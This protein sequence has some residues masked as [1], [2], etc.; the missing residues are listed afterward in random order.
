MSAH[1]GTS[2]RKIPRF[3][4]ILFFLLRNDFLP[5]DDLRFFLLDLL[6][7]RCLALLFRFFAASSAT[8]RRP[9]LGVRLG[10]LRREIR[11]SSVTEAS[12]GRFRLRRDR[13]AAPDDGVG[14]VAAGLRS[15][16]TRRMLGR[17]RGFITDRNRLSSRCPPLT[18]GMGG[19]RHRH[20]RLAS[21]RKVARQ[22]ERL[23]RLPIP[24]AAARRSAETRGTAD[25]GGGVASDSGGQT[26]SSASRSAAS[27][28]YLPVRS[29][30]GFL[31]VIPNGLARIT[32]SSKSGALR[33]H[34]PLLDRQGD[35]LLHQNSDPRANGRH[36]ADTWDRQRWRKLVV[37]RFVWCLCVAVDVRPAQHVSR[38]DRLVFRAFD[39]HPR[40]QDPAR[41]HLCF[42]DGVHLLARCVARK[43]VV[44]GLPIAARGRHRVLATVRPRTH[45]QGDG[46][47]HRSTPACCWGLLSPGNAGRQDQPRS[48]GRGLDRAASVTR[49]SR[50]IF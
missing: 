24:Q 20:P 43:S 10:M 38:R 27:D 42:P 8:A 36:M 33:S 39:V 6:A 30:S 34:A 40:G 5:R 14:R 9:I 11:T 22:V 12:A 26:Q 31:V 13:F 21:R 18:A 45:R 47:S 32:Y 29:W 35:A 3:I 50:L 49:G 1:E 37:R 15:G 16:E 46:R 41:L 44:V 19:A 17:F 48:S 7:G 23:L 28:L 25:L 2:G 4:G